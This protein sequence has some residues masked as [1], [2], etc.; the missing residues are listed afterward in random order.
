[1]AKTPPW[2]VYYKGEYIASCKDL[3]DAQAILHRRGVGCQIREGH[4]KILRRAEDEQIG[5]MT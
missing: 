4:R 1:M 5:K 2:K 3:L